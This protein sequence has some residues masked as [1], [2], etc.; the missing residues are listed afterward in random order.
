MVGRAVCWFGRS[1]VRLVGSLVGRLVGRLLG[2]LVGWSV[3]WLVEWLVGLVVG[4]DLRLFGWLNGRL[5]GRFAGYLVGASVGKL[6]CWLAGWLVTEPGTGESSRAITSLA[7]AMRSLGHAWRVHRTS[8]RSLSV[9]F[10]FS[11]SQAS[12]FFVFLIYNTSIKYQ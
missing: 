4:L 2:W 6:V 10:V 11:N 1:V 9:F 12:T 8:I 3:G 5:V 7:R